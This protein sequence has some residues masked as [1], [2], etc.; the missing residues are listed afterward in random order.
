MALDAIVVSQMSWEFEQTCTSVGK[1]LKPLSISHL[2]LQSKCGD[3]ELMTNSSE[4]CATRSSLMT[5]LWEVVAFCEQVE[6]DEAES[7]C[8]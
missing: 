1:I 8:G 2:A 6:I 3:D 5:M 4:A 7:A